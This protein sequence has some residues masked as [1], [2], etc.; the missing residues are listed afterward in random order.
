ML[1]PPDVALAVAQ[2]RVAVLVEVADVADTDEA[3]AAG[4]GARLGVA[5]IVEIR[6]RNLPHEDLAGLVDA[7]RLAVGTEDLDDAAFDGAA[8]GA[9]FCERLLG[10]M[11]HRESGFGRPKYSLMTGPHHSI[12][13]RLTCGGQGAAP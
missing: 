5:V 1:T 4:F 13:A 11:P 8:D 3:V 2:E 9:G 10:G 6:N 7:A 12:M